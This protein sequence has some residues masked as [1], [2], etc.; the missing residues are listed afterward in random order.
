VEG[1]LFSPRNG[2]LLHGLI[3]NRLDAGLFVIVS[4]IDDIRD[5]GEALLLSEATLKAWKI[6][7]LGLEMAEVRR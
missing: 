1:E 6:K 4:D 7:D 3:E 2:L 5:A